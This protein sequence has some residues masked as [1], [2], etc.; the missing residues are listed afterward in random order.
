[1]EI[2]I[3]T[4]HG[5]TIA[6]IISN[7]IELR[8]VQDALDIM[9]DCDYYQETRSIIMYKENIIP[10][11][12]DLSTGIAGE[13]LQKFSTYSVRLVIIGEFNGD[14]SKPLRDFIHESNRTG[15]IGFV[16]NMAAAMEFLR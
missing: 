9:A 2:K 4:K 13:V 3:H 11:F 6:E 1:M 14:L 12:F 7:K 10:D 16:E 5:K 15:R 8:R